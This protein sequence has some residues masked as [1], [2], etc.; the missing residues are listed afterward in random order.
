M[1]VNKI[2]IF[3][4][5]ISKQNKLVFLISTDKLKTLN[6]SI[7]EYETKHKEF[8]I[9]DFGSFIEL[10]QNITFV[11]FGRSFKLKIESTTHISH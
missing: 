10:L 6:F 11:V 8:S 4:V 1:R 5:I 2:V 7:T 3:N 9:N